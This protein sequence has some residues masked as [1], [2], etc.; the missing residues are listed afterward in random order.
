MKLQDFETLALAKARE[1]IT[2]QP[3][4]GNW[5][6]QFFGLYGILDVLEANKSNATAITV[7]PNNPTS[8]GAICRTI[9]GTIEQGVFIGDPSTADGQANLAASAVLVASGIYTQPT[10]DK[11]W[12]KARVE[13]T[14]FSNS[15]AHDWAVANND[16]TRF[17]KLDASAFQ[18][19]RCQITVDTSLNAEFEPHAPQ[20]YIEIFGKK[21]R[22]SGFSLISASGDYTCVVNNYRDVWVDNCYGVVV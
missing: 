13:T 3:I 21:E 4:S 2:Y 17:K 12:L 5:A 18:Q 1:V 16:Q 9:L 11:F 8:I 20:V 14:P 15:T 6:R 7:I 10:A 19:N 22:L